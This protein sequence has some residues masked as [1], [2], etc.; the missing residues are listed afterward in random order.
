M[1]FIYINMYIH[2]T[3]NLGPQ[4][5]YDFVAFHHHLSA[6][7]IMYQKLYYQHLTLVF[8]IQNNRC[9]LYKKSS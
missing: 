7:I 4:N 2:F 9:Y 6:F 8:E 3:S 1:L 5:L